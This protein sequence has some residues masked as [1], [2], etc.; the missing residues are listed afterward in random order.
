MLSTMAAWCMR[1]ET[2]M[3]KAPID[4]FKIFLHA[5]RFLISEEH[6]RRAEDPQMMSF[7]AA[8]SIVLSAFASELFLKCIQVLEKGNASSTHDLALLFRGLS[9]S[10]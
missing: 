3:A 9:S 7:I 2:E 10:A 6:L 5:Y 8:P 4:A 1:K